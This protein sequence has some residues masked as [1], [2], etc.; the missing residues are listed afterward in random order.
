MG[1]LVENSWLYTLPYTK[2][3]FTGYLLHGLYLYFPNIFTQDPVF[4]ETRMVVGNAGSRVKISGKYRFKPFYNLFIP[5][6][7]A[8]LFKEKKTFFNAQN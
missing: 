4:L 7:P 1:D 3:V 5:C 8:I 2:L 6:L